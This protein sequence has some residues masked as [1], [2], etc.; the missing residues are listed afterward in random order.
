VSN[1]T[2]DTVVLTDA[3]VTGTRASVSA[4]AV[5]APDGNVTADGLVG[6]TDNNSHL[7]S[8][9]AA[10]SVT[11]GE[12]YDYVAYVQQGAR[13]QV[14]LALSGGNF[15][16]NTNADFNLATGTVSGTGA[17][18]DSATITSVGG[19]WYKVVI[20]ATAATTGTAQMDLYARDAATGLAFAGDG[21]TVD[22]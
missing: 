9:T 8:N 18:V 15:A 2:Y 22:T 16:A 3:D 10:I 19:G 7:V 5:A 1:A 11:A 14:R 12:Q 17:G 20:T 13:S 4:D 6:S 21:A